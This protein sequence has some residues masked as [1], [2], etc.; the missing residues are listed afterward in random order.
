MQLS[1]T[2]FR[3]N[4]S[5]T[6]I[7][8]QSYRILLKPLLTSLPNS[9]DYK[10]TWFSSQQKVYSLKETKELSKSSFQEL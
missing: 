2:M 5:S 9:V 4:I 6:R 3:P 8:T 7:P 10:I 1:Q